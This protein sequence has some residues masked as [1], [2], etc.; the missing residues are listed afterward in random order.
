[1]TKYRRR[2]TPDSPINHN[3]LKLNY[4]L[5]SKNGFEMTVVQVSLCSA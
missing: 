4:L 1:M 5:E 3:K 2:I